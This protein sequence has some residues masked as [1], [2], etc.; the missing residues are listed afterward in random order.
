MWN[1]FR[2]RADTRSLSELIQA[3]RRLR[4][5]NFQ[6]LA[7]EW[8]QIIITVNTREALAGLDVGGGRLFAVRRRWGGPPLVPRY[9]RSRLIAGLVV[10]PDIRPGGFDLEYDWPYFISRQGIPVL[11]YHR[12]GI[13]A[14]GGPIVRDVSSR[15]RDAAMPLLRA[16]AERHAR[17]ML[18]KAGI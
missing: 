2:I 1:A 4:S 16:A 3:T 17:E 14:R 15:V 18:R 13:P 12:E 10:R 8:Q 11:R 5:P 7:G 6:P 9:G